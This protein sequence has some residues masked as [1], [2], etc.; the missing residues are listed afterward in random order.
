MAQVP[1]GHSG[2]L[3]CGRTEARPRAAGWHP[4]RRVDVEGWAALLPERGGSVPHPAARA[5][6]R[7]FGGRESPHA[8][9]GR[10]VARSGFRF[11]PVLAAYDHE[12]FT[13]LSRGITGR[14]YPLGA[15]EGQPLPR[16]GRGRG[17]VL[18][19]G[20]H[21]GAQPHRRRGG[22]QPVRGVPGVSGVVVLTCARRH[23]GGGSPRHAGARGHG[24]GLSG[25]PPCAAAGRGP[26]VQPA[27]RSRQA[28]AAAAAFA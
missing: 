17:G 24:V 14:L 25:R 4:G 1:A 23:G 9:P 3:W 16:D 7:E 21:R 26:R 5:F 10:N 13:C 20:Q 6:L 12:I 11:D 22:R 2:R 18:A 15:V 8:G 27:G 28:P 19:H